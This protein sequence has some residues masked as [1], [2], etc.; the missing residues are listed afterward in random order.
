[1]KTA[2]LMRYLTVLLAVFAL[3]GCDTL[4]REDNP[5]VYLQNDQSTYSAG[6]TARVV[7]FNMGVK[8]LTYGLCS[9][10]LRAEQTRWQHV[11]FGPDVVCVLI[12]FSLPYG[13]SVVLAYD[14]E[15]VPPGRYRLAY[16]YSETSGSS[17]KRFTGITQFVFYTSTF[18][19][20]E[21]QDVASQPRP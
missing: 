3:A 18:E 7:L 9:L 13:R 10:D 4:S 1:M 21:K 20:V 2:L 6:D 16:E 8:E 11:Y 5:G 15:G 17:T 12:G 14:L 19:V